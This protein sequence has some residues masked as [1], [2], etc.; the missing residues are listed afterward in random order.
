MV[1]FDHRGDELVDKLHI[2]I[3]HEDIVSLVDRVRERAHERFKVLLQPMRLQNLYN[4]ISF[5]H[6][7]QIIRQQA[8][9]IR[10]YVG[11]DWVEGLDYN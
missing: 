1:L 3:G 2:I 6:P 4:V 5:L 10:S 9:T 11:V 7:P 8:Q